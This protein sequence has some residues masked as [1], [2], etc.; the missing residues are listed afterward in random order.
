MELKENVE[1][2]ENEVEEEKEEGR[3][4][5]DCPVRRTESGRA[6]YCGH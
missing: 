3:T 2:Y 1:D 6:N 5:Y 4:E